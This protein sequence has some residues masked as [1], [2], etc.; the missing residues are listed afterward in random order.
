METGCQGADEDPAVEKLA[1]PS[2]GPPLLSSPWR[3]SWL[4]G[5]VPTHRGPEAAAEGGAGAEQ[6]EARLES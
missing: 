4:P 3:P 2:A 1:F 5:R 6:T